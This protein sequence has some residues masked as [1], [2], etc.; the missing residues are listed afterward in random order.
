ME[1]FRQDVHKEDE[2]EEVEGVQCPA[3]ETGADR[4]E[5]LGVERET[6]RPFRCHYFLATI[7]M[8]K[9]LAW[10][11]QP[12][13][14]SHRHTLYCPKRCGPS[15]ARV[16]VKTPDIITAGRRIADASKRNR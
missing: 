5:L 12:P 6:R 4:V 9:S 3:K 15:V 13:A 14:T 10:K 7:S 16:A 1:V 8:T 2:D 11:R